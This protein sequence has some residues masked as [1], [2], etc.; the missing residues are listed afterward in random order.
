MKCAIFCSMMA[1]SALA[2]PQISNV[3]AEQNPKTGLVEI[4]YML[5]EDAVVTFDDLLVGGVSLGPSNVT[6]YAGHVSVKVKGGDNVVRKI[7]W[8][9]PKDVPGRDFDGTLTAKLTAWPLSSPPN[10]LVVDLDLLDATNFFFYASEA[11]LPDGGITSDVYRT[12]KLLLRKIP[13]AGVVFRMGDVSDT[14]AVRFAE[15]YEKFEA[16]W[17]CSVFHL[18][19]G[20]YAQVISTTL[21]STSNCKPHSSDMPICGISY[22]DLR[23]TNGWPE[24]GHAVTPGSV[25]GKFRTR[26]GL[27]L[28]L[29]TDA[30]WEYSCRAGTSSRFH[31]GSSETG[32][33]LDIGWYSWYNKDTQTYSGNAT[34]ELHRAGVK[35]PNK[36][37]L[38]D[39]HGQT[40]VWCLDWAAGN[41]DWQSDDNAWFH[42][43]YNGPRQQ[44]TVGGKTVWVNVDPAGPASTGKTAV[45]GAAYTTRA[46]RGGGCANG[47]NN[48]YSHFRHN[49]KPTTINL[50]YSGAR[51]VCPVP[52]L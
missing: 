20:Q 29:P 22:D 15:H 49:L 8:N 52:A 31:N 40:F 5:S 16:D 14:S 42:H 1:M 4:S 38:Y 47:V 18:T 34:G 23:G 12:T 28:D 43:D 32:K 50:G 21:P 26:T 44:V 11:N 46:V 48:A 33:A 24:A 10:Y 35:L 9:A 51:F 3:T 2:T 7:V 17:Y 30:Q 41:D 25:I 19:Q 36:W 39:M 27:M 6:S 37:G 45:S 13:A